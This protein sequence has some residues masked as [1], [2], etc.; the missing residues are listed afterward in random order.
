MARLKVSSHGEVEPTNIQGAKPLDLSRLNIFEGPD[1]IP[2]DPDA[3]RKAMLAQNSREAMGQIVNVPNTSSIQGGSSGSNG[4][5]RGG[6]G[7]KN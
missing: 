6:N 1:R 2:D 3:A 5:R 4:G 7:Y